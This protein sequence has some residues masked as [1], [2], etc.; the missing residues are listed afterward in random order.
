MTGRGVRVRSAV[1]VLAVAAAAAAVPATAV[2]HQA[3]SSCDGLRSGYTAATPPN[4]GR[5]EPLVVTSYVVDRWRDNL[6]VA[7]NGFTI[8]T[9]RDLGCHWTRSF[10]TE[11][12]SPTGGTSPAGEISD[13]V[14][15]PDG[16][17][18]AVVNP[19]EVTVSA[20]LSA[21]ALDYL[22]PVFVVSGDSGRTW[23]RRPVGDPLS[24]RHVTTVLSP[25]VGR[26]AA[27]LYALA[28]DL[29][30]RPLVLSSPDAGETWAV[31]TTADA[32]GVPSQVSAMAV[33]PALRDVWLA[34]T[35]VSHSSDGGHTFADLRG[36]P[37]PA[38]SVAVAAGRDVAVVADGTLWRGPGRWQRM[39]TAE[40]G[41]VTGAVFDARDR[42]WA[43]TTRPSGGSLY[44]F[45]PGAPLEAAGPL[46]DTV[47]DQPQRAAQGDVV[48]V[49]AA[50][51]A[52]TYRI[53]VFELD[54]FHPE[55]H[56]TFHA[57][58][59]A[60]H[61]ECYANPDP[62][63]PTA[64]QP[65]WE[66]L[67]ANEPW[68]YLTDFA[69][70]STFRLDRYGRRVQVGQ[71][72]GTPEATA[73]DPFGRVV[74]SGRH[75][76]QLQRLDPLRCR[77]DVLDSDLPFN[78]G[79]TFDSAGNLFVSSTEAARIWEY[80][81]PQAVPARR[82]LVYDFRKDSTPVTMLEDVRAAPS[83]TRYAGDLF[84]LVF[85]PGAGVSDTGYPEEIARLHRSSDGTWHRS[86]FWTMPPRF[87]A[88]GFAFRPNG[89]LLLPDVIGSGRILRLSADGKTSSVF[90]VATPASTGKTLSRQ[91]VK[92][93]VAA[94]GIAYVTAPDASPDLCPVGGFTE[95]GGEAAVYRFDATGRQ[96]EPTLTN[97]SR[98]TLGISVIHLF[99]D[100]PRTVT[101]L[102]R[103]GPDPLPKAKAPPGG[104]AAIPLA[105]AA[106]A[107]Q[108]PVQTP[109]QPVSQP[110]P[111]A[112]QQAQQQPNQ[113]Q[114]SQSQ[115]DRSLG[116]I[117]GVQPEAEPELALQ[118]ESAPRAR[119][120]QP[121]GGRGGDSSALFMMSALVLTAAAG[122][123][124]VRR[125]QFATE[126]VR[127]WA[128]R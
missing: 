55:H 96:I 63:P 122:A 58:N 51:A 19:V 82:H 10:S 6:F 1:A 33:G 104:A 117:F 93:D 50:R 31:T 20:N 109:P 105:G 13:L 110:Q 15:M 66:P 80:P 97:V 44:L 18:G 7:T 78:E 14:T 113:Q 36:A 59:A 48:T 5:G 68:I 67:P 85:K 91:L 108:P 26:A 126:P 101:D 98:C 88:A 45:R 37:H 16:A 111:Q 90:A 25:G 103:P 60:I 69:Y 38:T 127:A 100:L 40:Q 128:D 75:S 46:S 123:V 12:S 35:S 89:E 73:L 8:M 94:S 34:G 74:I 77:L 119:S 41:T 92:I 118:Y 65:G 70:G 17:I 29:R 114:Q 120:R 21:P 87:N 9:S 57:P 39:S 27:R 86:L 125:R 61:D 22:N 102:T 47:L 121:N 83:G 112:Q 99:P 124:A 56:V 24:V 76:S 43:T 49:R 42:V 2:G 3:E 84:V 116:F 30:S 23:D 52:R 71:T 79:P 115:G 81:W 64:W 107:A 53:G 95:L 32:A 28:Q 11:V 54:G 106:Y 62:P 72:A 4:F